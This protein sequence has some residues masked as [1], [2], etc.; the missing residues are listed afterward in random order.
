MI[1]LADGTSSGDR[2]RGGDRYGSSRRYGGG[3]G[4]GGEDD[5]TAGDWRSG[6]SSSSFS[7]KDDDYNRP[8]RGGGAGYDRYESRD[9]RYD[10]GEAPCSRADFFCG[11]FVG[12]VDADDFFPHSDDRRDGRG[13]GFREDRYS[14]DRRS[15]FDRRDGRG[16]GGFDR[17]SPGK[18]NTMET[19]QIGKIE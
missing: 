1:D 19:G 9:N 8:S 2:E 11:F 14:S 5:R 13:Y 15:G 12:A 10:R 16:G 17:R 18:A 3:G 7:S 6:P 4:G